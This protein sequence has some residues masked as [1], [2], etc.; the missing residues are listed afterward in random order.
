MLA[1]IRIAAV[2]QIDVHGIFRSVQAFRKVHGRDQHIDR[3][4]SKPHAGADSL[5]R[6]RESINQLPCDRTVEI[7]RMAA[8]CKTVL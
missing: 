5:I 2:A 7:R 3:P 1:T 8:G 4:S 6:Y